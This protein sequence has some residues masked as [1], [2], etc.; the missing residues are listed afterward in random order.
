MGL[1][2][3][4][5]EAGGRGVTRNHRPAGLMAASDIGPLTSHHLLAE[6]LPE[7]PAQPGSLG[8]LG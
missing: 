5:S 3:G 8:G 2:C 7:V 4:L 6:T 1:P